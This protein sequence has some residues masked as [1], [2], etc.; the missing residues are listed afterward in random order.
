MIADHVG[1]M[2]NPLNLRRHRSAQG[3]AE[4]LDR[5]ARSIAGRANA[6][7]LTPLLRAALRHVGQANGGLRTIA[8]FAAD[9]AISRSSAARTIDGL[10]AEG[11]AIKVPGPD[12][13]QK[14]LV[15]TSRGRRVLSEDPVVA[16]STDLLTLTDDQLFEVAEA[17]EILA[18]KVLIGDRNAST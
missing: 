10:V 3:V 6:R 11:L 12:S 2:P 5:M 1:N 14:A 16:L 4:L 18:R 17:I 9:H 15:L 13:R 7:G 8:T